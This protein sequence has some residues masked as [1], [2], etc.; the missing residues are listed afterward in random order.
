MYF[1][2]TLTKMFTDKHNVNTNDIILYLNKLV[3]F[4]CI[5]I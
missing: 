2:K 1:F 4:F 5:F 3:L